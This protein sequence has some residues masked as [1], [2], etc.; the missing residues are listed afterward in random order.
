MHGGVGGGDDMG[1]HD[2]GVHGM[3]CAAWLRV[4]LV[5]SVC[6][7]ARCGRAWHGRP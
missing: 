7:C 3:A 2:V 6:M 5:C 1:L 4:A